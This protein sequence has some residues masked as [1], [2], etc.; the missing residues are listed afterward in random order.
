[1]PTI[2]GS[3]ANRVRG[4]GVEAD[5]GDPGTADVIVFRAGDR[6]FVACT[7]GESLNESA[8]QWMTTVVKTATAP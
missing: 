7:H 8:R 2:G 6:L 5:D 1:V 4:T 3:A